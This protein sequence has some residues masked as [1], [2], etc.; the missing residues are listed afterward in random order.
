V[1]YSEAALKT[2]V[3]GVSLLVRK[4]LLVVRLDGTCIQSESF[5]NQVK[6]AGSKGIVEAAAMLLAR[7]DD[8]AEPMTVNV[9][10]ILDGQVVTPTWDST[11][12]EDIV[13]VSALVGPFTIADVASESNPLQVSVQG[14]AALAGKDVTFGLASSPSCQFPHCLAA[15]TVTYE[16]G[17]TKELDLRFETPQH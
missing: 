9:H 6:H 14:T 10:V 13:K 15:E 17:Q 1:G 2:D 16:P 3:N 11:R 12:M 7:A 8:S 4:G 5:P